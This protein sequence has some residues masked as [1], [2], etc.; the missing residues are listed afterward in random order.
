[1]TQEERAA[2]QFHASHEQL[3]LSLSLDGLI[4]AGQPPQ[5]Q[6]RRLLRPV[7]LTPPAL[8]AAPWPALP[9]PPPPPPRSSPATHAARL[10]PWPSCVPARGPPPMFLLMVGTTASSR[11]PSRQPFC[12][13]PTGPRRAMSPRPGPPAAPRAGGTE[14]EATLPAQRRAGLGVPGQSWDASGATPFSRPET[15]ARMGSNSPGT[16]AEG[17]DKNPRLWAPGRGLGP[18][19]TWALRRPAGLGSTPPS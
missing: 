15:E 16:T 7:R 10:V 1:M 17:P 3:V 2:S 14:P 4:P 12:P 5:L 18:A 19:V 11:K 8:P 13:P 6:L 9:C